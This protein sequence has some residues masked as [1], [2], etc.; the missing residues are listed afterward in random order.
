MLIEAIEGRRPEQPV[1]D[2]GFKVI[3][4]QSSQAR[5]ARQSLGIDRQGGRLNKMIALPSSDD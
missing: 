3:E 1:L 4:R 5:P 2:L